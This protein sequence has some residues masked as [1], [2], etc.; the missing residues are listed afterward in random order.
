MPPSGGGH[1]KPTPEIVPIDGHVQL[2]STFRY[3]RTTAEGPLAQQR[4]VVARTLTD[5]HLV[6]IPMI[7][8]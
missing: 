1:R 6:G 7:S 5:K 2:L 8:G 3:E 4:L